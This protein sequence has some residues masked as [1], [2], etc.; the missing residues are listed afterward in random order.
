MIDNTPAGADTLKVEEL[1]LVPL[2]EYFSSAPENFGLTL[3][4]TSMFA[5]LLSDE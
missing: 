2:K 5:D 4:F 1:L 3:V